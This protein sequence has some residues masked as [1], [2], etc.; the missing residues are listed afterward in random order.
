MGNGVGTLEQ[1]GGDINL[2]GGNL[3]VAVGA[4]AEFADGTYTMNGGTLRINAGNIYAVGNRGNGTVTQSA[5][6]PT[7]A[8]RWPTRQ[9]AR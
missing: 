6:R 4:A 7:S 5:A 9:P 1:S 3:N 2:N 8:A